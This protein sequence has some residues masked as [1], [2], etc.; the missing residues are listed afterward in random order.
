MRISYILLMIFCFIFSNISFAQDT[1]SSLDPVVISAGFSPTQSSKKGRNIIVVKGELIA[2]LPVNS[3][4]ELLR[5]LPGIEV[6]ARGPMGVQSDISIRGSTFQQ[7]LVILDGIRLNDPLTGHFSS[8]IP[9]PPVEI[10]RIEILKGA[11]SAIYG[12]EAV[13][14][15]VHIIT[16]TFA[17]TSKK[18][19][20]EAQFTGGEYGFWGIN[21][22]GQWAKE[23]TILSAGI[24]S[25]HADG[26][27]QR[28]TTGLFDLTSLSLGLSQKLG[29]HWTLGL[30]SAYD[31]RHFAAQ[32]FYTTFVS[33]SAKERIESWWQH[34]QLAFHKGPLRW[35]T[36]IG[37]KSLQDVYAFNPRSVANNN[38]TQ[39]F[40]MLSKATLELSANA[41]FTGGIQYIDRGIKS[42]D[43]G[44]HHVWQTAAFMVL[45]YQP[46]PGLH[47]DPSLRFDLHE[48]AGFELVPQ[49]NISYSKQAYQLRGSIG[50]TI[51]DADFTERFN[52]FNRIL[53][54]SGRIGN[55]DLEA[56]SG[57]NYEVGVDFWLGK[58]WKISNS[59]FVRDQ[60]KLI[61]W[62]NTP[63]NEMPRRENLLPNGTYA[64]SKN[65]W[66][67]NTLGWETDVQYHH[68]FS[69][70]QSLMLQAGFL[71]LNTSGNDNTPSLYLSTQAKWLVNFNALYRYKKWA[72]SATG[73]YK[74]R[75]EQKT[76][77]GINAELTPEY[78]LLNMKLEFSPFK[79]WSVFAQA[80]NITDVKYSDLLGSAMPG[81]WWMGGVMV[82]LGK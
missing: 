52:N 67:V 41:S 11:A 18:N 76:N 34:G 8:Y 13:G 69:K 12:T 56:E 19:S 22:G 38:K 74:K 43:R 44:D 72:I 32:N 29:T 63:Y 20:L 33:D 57:W 39:L 1:L 65:I 45:Q 58:G 42:N 23:N 75:D 70:D 78:F 80:D 21:A 37:Y 77:G 68:A 35:T 14:G 66:D 27:P 73:L 26:Q 47:I 17:K 71:W 50:R 40:Q 16:K 48:R 28:G 5:Y 46:A 30:R 31:N 6:Q 7:V 9:L 62:V 81:R 24:I 53:V 82:K 54:P 36:D 3:V 15:V 60:S 10:E 79:K 2:N 49:L 51:R 61:D 25:N 4:D 59:F 55:P 64:L